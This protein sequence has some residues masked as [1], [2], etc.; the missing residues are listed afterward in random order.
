LLNTLY[1]L[2]KLN[3]GNNIYDEKEKFIQGCPY[4]NSR[5]HSVDIRSVYSNN[6][7]AKYIGNL[8]QYLIYCIRDYSEEFCKI[9]IKKFI[10]PYKGRGQFLKLFDQYFIDVKIKKQIDNIK[11]PEVQTFIRKKLK[12]LRYNIKFL[13]PE[14]V[15]QVLE[16][17]NQNEK[18]EKINRIIHDICKFMDIYLFSR[19]FRSFTQ[20]KGVYSE[21]PK[22]IIIYAGSFHTQQYSKW[23]KKHLKFEVKYSAHTLDTNTEEQ[24]CIEIKGFM[25]EFLP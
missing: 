1:K 15:E 10:T 14:Y 12:N 13:S 6:F 20:I 9:I 21:D 5:I 2:S 23:L 11:Y 17:S 3:C 22:N 4:K 25:P 24:N 8:T 16:I 18:N 19:M 7:F